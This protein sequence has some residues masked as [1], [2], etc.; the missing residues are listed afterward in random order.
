MCTHLLL[1][2]DPCQQSGFDGPRASLIIL[3]VFALVCSGKVAQHQSNSFSKKEG[4][5]KADR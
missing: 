2:A 5:K 3:L 1:A 4:K